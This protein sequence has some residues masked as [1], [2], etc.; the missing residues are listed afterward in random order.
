[1]NQAAMRTIHNSPPVGRAPWRASA[2]ALL[3]FALAQ[4]GCASRYTITLNNGNKI[5]THG[6][7]RLTPG[8][9]ALI[10]K[11]AKNEWQS[12]PSGKVREV[13]PR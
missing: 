7:P 8:K 3:V 5:T 2:A 4:A 1:M 11:D 10:F 6:K 9:D 12:I 13:A